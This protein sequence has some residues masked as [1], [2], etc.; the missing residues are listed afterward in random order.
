MSALRDR[1]P[2]EPTV[3]EIVDAVIGDPDFQK[4]VGGS[5]RAG[6][7]AATAVRA[8]LVYI[9]LFAMVEEVQHEVAG[10]G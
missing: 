4:A 5:E 3:E 1:T 7:I 6:M 8:A 2:E 10:H 9:G